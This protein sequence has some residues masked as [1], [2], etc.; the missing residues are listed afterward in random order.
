MDNND[1]FFINFEQKL[2]DL[3]NKDDIFSNPN[4]DIDN[5]FNLKFNTVEE[6]KEN[7][8]IPDSFM[9]PDLKSISE[10]AIDSR[11]DETIAHFSGKR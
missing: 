7:N 4:F 5:R 2:S 8:I 6:Y 9:H 1:E 3:F 11:N 10:F